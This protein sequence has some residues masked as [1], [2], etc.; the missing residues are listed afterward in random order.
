[1]GGGTLSSTSARAR[2]T[3]VPEAP[4]FAPG[5][6]RSRSAGSRALS[7]SGRVSQCASRRMRVGSS[8]RN[9]A[10]RF[11]SWRRRP[12]AARWVN[13]WIQSVS[14]W[15]RKIE[16]SQSRAARCATVPGMRGPKAIWSLT[17]LSRRSAESPGGAAPS[18]VPPE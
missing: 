4:S 15:I 2:R 10:R 13:S 9:R 6:G 11:R 14:A 8:G 1:M 5:T 16:S 12:S 3:A 18:V 7:E 17:K